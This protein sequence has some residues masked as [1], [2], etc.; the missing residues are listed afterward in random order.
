LSGSVAG[1]AATLTR[2][3]YVP[4]ALTWESFPPVPDFA[5]QVGI[6]DRISVGDDRM[7]SVGLRDGVLSCVH[8]ALLPPGNPTTCAVQCWDVPIS[9]WTP[10]VF[11]IT[12]PDG[13]MLAHPS[14][15]VNDRGDKLIGCSLLSAA[16]HPSGAYYCIPSGAAPQPANVF[17]AGTDTYLKVLKVFGGTE[18]RWGDYS[19]TMTDPENDRDFWTVQ[20]CSEPPL[21]GWPE[22]GRWATKIVQVGAP[23]AGVV[24]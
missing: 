19:A 2:V 24:S 7:L 8:M 6:A 5:P 1:G 16:R 9:T 14:H 18:N 10:S 11:R 4:S 13:G 17:A 21:P 3:G 12:D 20:A 22:H 15:A 23:S